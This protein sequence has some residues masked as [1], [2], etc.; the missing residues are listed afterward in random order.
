M[1]ASQKFALETAK[2]I[3][4]AALQGCRDQVNGDLGV[5]AARYFEEVYKKV[6][7]LAKNESDK[8]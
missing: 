5:Y 7:E 8:D 3:T 6:L 4:I 1:Y 2:E